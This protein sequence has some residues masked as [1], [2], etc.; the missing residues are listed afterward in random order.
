MEIRLKFKHKICL[1]DFPSK[2]VLT[3]VETGKGNKQLGVQFQRNLHAK[4]RPPGT[5]TFTSFFT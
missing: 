5:Q 2:W 1:G 3:D 4:R